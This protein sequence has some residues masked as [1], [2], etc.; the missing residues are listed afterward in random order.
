M[1]RRTFTLAVLAILGAAAAFAVATPSHSATPGSGT[2]TTAG[3][4]KG[5]STCTFSA[6]AAGTSISVSC[7]KGI[8]DYTVGTCDTP[9][10]FSGNGQPTGALQVGNFSG[11]NN[12]TITDKG[13]VIT[14]L[15]L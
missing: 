12:A 7:S 9:I 14:Q 8:S 2:T 1:K 6:N 4:G 5:Q 13:L 15:Y 11:G 10:D 3:P